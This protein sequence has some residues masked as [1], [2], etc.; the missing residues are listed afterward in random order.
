[1]LKAL[2]LRRWVSVPALA[3]ALL[4]GRAPA[5]APRVYE[6]ILE[7]LRKQGYDTTRLAKT[8]QATAAQ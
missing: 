6:G 8:L 3:C 2:N 1:M 4:A 7:R 5:L